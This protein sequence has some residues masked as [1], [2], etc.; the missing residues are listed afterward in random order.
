MVDHNQ[1]MT[2]YHLYYFFL[3]CLVIGVHGKL[4]RH[5]LI[6]VC[7]CMCG[8]LFSLCVCVCV[9]VS[10]CVCHTLNSGLE[11]NMHFH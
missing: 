1:L 3:I 7:V 10:I 2:L 4:F 5:D 8:L 11:L 6:L 9:C